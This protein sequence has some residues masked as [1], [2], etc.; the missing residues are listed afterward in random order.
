[1][2]RFALVFSSSFSILREW[3]TN[4]TC[5]AAA[6]NTYHTHAYTNTHG[7]VAFHVAP[8]L[9]SPPPWSNQ[10]DAFVQTGSPQAFRPTPPASVRVRATN[11]EVSFHFPISHPERL[12]SIFT[13]RHIH[14]AVD[15]RGSHALVRASVGAGG[16]TKTSTL[17]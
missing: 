16:H 15:S 17:V 5:V 3:R 1:M 4:R 14:T 9:P 2:L 11:V 7:V 12:T 10:V 13:S 6:Q 8:P